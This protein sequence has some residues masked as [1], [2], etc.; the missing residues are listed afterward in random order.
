M[1]SET[2]NVVIDGVAYEAVRVEM[3]STKPW[4]T[5]DRA[6]GSYREELLQRSG[7]VSLW[8]LNSGVVAYV[9]DKHRPYSVIDGV[10]TIAITGYLTNDAWWWDET[11]YGKIKAEI[12]TAM[13]DPEVRGVLLDIDSPGGEVTNAFETRD[14]IVALARKP[15]WAAA[16]MVAYS[17][18]YLMATVAER[19]YSPAITGGVGSIGVYCGHVDVSDAL[20]QQGV[21]VTLVSAGE[22]KTDGNPYEPLSDKARDD[23]QAEVMRL[24]G[25]FVDRVAAARPIEVEDVVALGAYIYTGKD[26]VVGGL[27]DKVGSI[28]DAHADMVAYLNE[29]QFSVSM[30]ATAAV[31]IHKPKEALSMTEPQ[32]AVA[33]KALPVDVEKLAADAKAEGRAERDTELVEIQ[34]LCVIF[35]KPELAAAFTD[36]TVI[37]VR[38][39]FLSERAT[40]DEAT[41][42]DGSI[43]ANMGLDADIDSV[44][45]ECDK[46]A[47][48]MKGGR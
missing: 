2:S 30:A 37:E 46:I 28:E 33:E 11:E 5:I 21:K 12:A 39:A 13:A 24:Y 48:K 20:K 29:K 8:T 40:E 4:A 43:T 23:M 1:S 25:E 44:V 15:I 14:E 16:N 3:R 45:K 26:A 17:G 42:T 47:A 38:D 18:A 31:P 34:Q 7:P 10:A 27:A 36:K 22:G 9:T 6:P 19:I 32:A 41:T 35:G